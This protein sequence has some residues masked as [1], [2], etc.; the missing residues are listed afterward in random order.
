[1]AVHLA[2]KVLGVIRERKMERPRGWNREVLVRFF[3]NKS[4]FRSLPAYGGEMLSA[5][6]KARNAVKGFTVPAECFGK[7]IDRSQANS[8]RLYIENTI[9]PAMRLAGDTGITMD[10]VGIHL[11]GWGD[12]VSVVIYRKG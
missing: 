7:A 1:M 11:D 3:V 6:G 12:D 9:L 2:D 8:I 5:E 4:G 10:M